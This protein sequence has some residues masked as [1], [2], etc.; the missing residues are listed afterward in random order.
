MIAN[1]SQQPHSIVVNLQIA[2]SIIIA[3]HLVCLESECKHI[4]ATDMANMKA[5]H[6]SGNNFRLHH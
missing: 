4:V 3:S 2:L 6:V 5:I 1:S